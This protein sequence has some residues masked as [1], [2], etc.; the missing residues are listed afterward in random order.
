MTNPRDLVQVEV[1][2]T[3]DRSFAGEVEEAYPDVPLRQAVAILAKFGLEAH[4]ITKKMI[5]IR[6]KH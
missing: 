5:E 4:R 6:D 2:V 1:L 3:I